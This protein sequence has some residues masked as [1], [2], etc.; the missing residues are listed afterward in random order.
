MYLVESARFR[1]EDRLD[2]GKV[3]D[4]KIERTNV[5]GVVKR[6]GADGICD[7]ERERGEREE[8]KGNGKTGGTGGD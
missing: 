5:I 1:Q 4:R 2:G 6:P 8:E 3:N 7:S